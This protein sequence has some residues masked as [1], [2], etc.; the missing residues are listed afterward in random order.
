M[1]E[2]E[3]FHNAWLSG[4]FIKRLLLLSRPENPQSEP[5]STSPPPAAAPTMFPPSSISR[6]ERFY[7]VTERQGAGAAMKRSAGVAASETL[8][9][10]KEGSSSSLTTNEGTEIEI[11]ETNLNLAIKCG[12]LTLEPNLGQTLGKPALVLQESKNTTTLCLKERHNE[13]RQVE[14]LVE[15]LFLTAPKYGFITGDLRFQNLSGLFNHVISP[16]HSPTH[17]FKVTFDSYENRL[18]Y[19]SNCILMFRVT[20]FCTELTDQWREEEGDCDLRIGGRIVWDEIQTMVTCSTAPNILNIKTH[21]E[22][23]IN[24]QKKYSCTHDF[25]HGNPDKEKPSRPTIFGG[26]SV[27]YSTIFQLP[28][29]TLNLSTEHNWDGDGATGSEQGAAPGHHLPIPIVTCQLHSEF[30]DS[31]GLATIASN[32]FFLHDLAQR[33]TRK[34]EKHFE[35]NPIF[36]AKGAGPSSSSTPATPVKDGD[37]TTAEKTEETTKF[38]REFVTDSWELKPPLRLQ[39]GGK[40]NP[41]VN[42]VLKKLGFKNPTVTI[43]KSIQRGPMDP[44]DYFVSRLVKS[45]VF[46]QAEIVEDV[47]GGSSKK[48]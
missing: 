13:R 38:A 48:S 25:A 45:L 26:G 19:L 34:M 7:S 24:Q 39:G 30:R 2:V 37:G 17:T 9:E 29:M 11:A 33:Y 15:Q 4:Q 28:E 20:G 40:V 27:E 22:D 47:K 32:Y 46:Q 31:I 6:N 21:V 1:D 5:P 16:D 14:I 10:I 41:N 3:S 8:K 42:W 44:L 12:K 43:P 36:G 35:A 18:E 23:F